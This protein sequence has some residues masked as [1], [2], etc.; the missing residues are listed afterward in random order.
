MKNSLKVLSL[1]AVTAAAFAAANPALAGDGKA[2][3]GS[4]CKALSPN[5]NSDQVAYNSRGGVLNISSSSSVRVVCP[6][7]R[8][9]SADMTAKVYIVDGNSG[10]NQNVSC[11]LKSISRTGAVLGQSTRRSNSSF[12]NVLPL[13]FNSR[14]RGAG[15]AGIYF[16]CVIPPRQQR[17]SEIVS[18]EVTEL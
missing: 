3:S 1:A 11:T 12:S 5:I 14:V 17:F 8:D 9:T 6:A 4:E 2:Y 7:V 15:G 16:E 13:E 10:S 18:Y